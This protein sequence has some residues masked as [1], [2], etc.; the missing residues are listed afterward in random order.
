MIFMQKWC[1]FHFPKYYS[2]ILLF[3]T[4]LEARARSQHLLPA[5]LMLGLGVW[6]RAATPRGVWGPKTAE[7]GPKTAE[8]GPPLPARQA[9]EDWK[10]FGQGNGKALAMTAPGRMQKMMQDEQEQEGMEV[11]VGRDQGL[12]LDG[13]AEGAHG[14]H[15][16]R[17]LAT[18][19]PS[20][21]TKGPAAPR[22]GPGL[23]GRASI[24]FL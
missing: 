10:H 14:Q 6:S 21:R 17:P 22:A 3:F 5:E 11:L 12:A 20:R 9:R 4:G 13:K 16:L 1:W 18:A 19:R 7:L 15:R 23:W 24:L 2:F 8:L